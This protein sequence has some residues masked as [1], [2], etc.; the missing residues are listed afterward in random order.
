MASLRL[1]EILCLMYSGALFLIGAFMVGYALVLCFKVFYHFKFVPSEMIGPFIVIML[2]GIV[3]I[4]ITWVGVKGPSKEHD[5]FIIMFVV[6]SVILM[7]VEMTIG[8]WSLVLRS[9][10]EEKS[11]EVMKESHLRFINHGYDKKEWEMLEKKLH[12]CGLNGTADYYARGEIPV[13]CMNC[14]Q[15]DLINKKSCEA[16]QTGCGGPFN[17]Y[18]KD[19]L[20]QSALVGLLTGLYQIAG[21][22]A[23]VMFYRGLKAERAVRALNRSRSLQRR[24]SQNQTS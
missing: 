1:K 23:F 6:L 21:I 19:L 18:V 22:V 12:C 16:H 14:T 9:E 10:V 17:Q 2:V 4:F 24:Q 20:L 15:E 13:S 3:H 5:F 8:V 7:V 11:F